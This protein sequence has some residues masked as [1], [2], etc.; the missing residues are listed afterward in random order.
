MEKRPVDRTVRPER[1]PFI[2][3]GLGRVTFAAPDRGF[4]ERPV[5]DVALGVASAEGIG[6]GTA[7]EGTAAKGT[8]AEGTAIEGTVAEELRT[9]N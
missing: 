2:G 6:E 9:E 8:A 4:D 1:E 7:A 3:K 5:D